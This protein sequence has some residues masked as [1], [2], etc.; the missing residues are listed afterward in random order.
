MFNDERINYEITKL[1]KLIII[2]SGILSF[3][4]LLFKMLILYNQKLH[5]CLYSTEIIITATSLIIM[6]CSLFIKTE[7]KDEMYLYKKQKYYD[8]SFKGFLRIIG[9]RHHIF[10]ISKILFL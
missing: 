10:S 3:M 7:V 5:F 4:F 9:Y 6:I 8:V 1:K 2:V